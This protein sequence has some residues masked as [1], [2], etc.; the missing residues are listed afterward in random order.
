M[1]NGISPAGEAT[2]MQALLASGAGRPNVIAA[3]TETGNF[4]GHDISP[5]GSF[6]D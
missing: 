2:A 1:E 5:S 3:A 6:S 4:D